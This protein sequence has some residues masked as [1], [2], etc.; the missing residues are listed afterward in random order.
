MSEQYLV[1]EPMFVFLATR[2]EIHAA[3]EIPACHI[4][5]GFC[6]SPTFITVDYVDQIS[7]SKNEL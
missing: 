6:L 3:S 4:S 7:Q 2:E 1:A 5:Y